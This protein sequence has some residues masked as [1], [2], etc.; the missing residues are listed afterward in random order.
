MSW[1]Y[2]PITGAPNEA[3]TVQLQLPRN[4]V[5][6]WVSRPRGP[7]SGRRAGPES[8]F[9]RGPCA[10]NAASPG[11]A[12]AGQEG[13]QGVGR[14]P[15]AHWW[16]TQ[17]PGTWRWTREAPQREAC[18]FAPVGGWRDLDAELQ[19]S[20]AP[21]DCCF[22]L[23]ARGA[24][25]HHVAGGGTRRLGPPTFAAG[26]LC[27]PLAGTC[28]VFNRGSVGLVCG[29][30]QAWENPQAA[31][32]PRFVR[33]SA[34]SLLLPAA[35][36]RG[37]HHW[38][39]L[40]EAGVEL[41]EGSCGV[42]CLSTTAPPGPVRGPGPLN[43]ARGH[44]EPS[45]KVACPADAS[46][47][48]GQTGRA[49]PSPHADT[50]PRG[51]RPPL[52]VC[53]WAPSRG[54]LGQEEGGLGTGDPAGQHDGVWQ[55]SQGGGERPLSVG[56]TQGPLGGRLLLQSCRGFLT[57]GYFDRVGT[58]AAVSRVLISCS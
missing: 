5:P 43:A 22:G 36:S 10:A 45:P 58:G 4:T 39:Q 8:G 56:G 30:W 13:W 46:H 49:A 12:K 44:E 14:R 33:G 15:A 35:V 42:L 38:L 3:Q 1:R 17:V 19:Q 32:T 28:P 21:G 52:P 23:P 16:G 18:P 55:G 27:K 50:C 7:R 26:Q 37:A 24:K 40:P 57:P 48:G 29:S 20:G 9:Q 47:P 53:T 6:I 31:R 54:S 11:E 41:S 34:S 25:G 2:S 51:R